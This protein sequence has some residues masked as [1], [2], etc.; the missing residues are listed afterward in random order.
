MEAAR[1]QQDPGG[2]RPPG[3]PPARYLSL[4]AARQARP[5]RGP[6]S[7]AFLPRPAPPRAA[8]PFLLPPARRLRLTGLAPPH[9]GRSPSSHSAT[10]PSWH[11][12]SV[13]RP[14]PRPRLS[15][16][17]SQGPAGSPSL[18]L[19]SGPAARHAGRSVS[20][21]AESPSCLLGPFLRLR[22]SWHAQN[23][24]G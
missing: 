8:R 1:G 24:R 16:G 4:G 6:S 17:A 3:Q 2:R 22:D 11:S 23:V 5:R 7:S 18:G 19:V 14:G 20:P 21:R 13:Q 9:S 12:A 15:P 10:S